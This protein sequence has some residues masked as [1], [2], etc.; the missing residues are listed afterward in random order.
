M[1]SEV[2]ILP[3]RLHNQRFVR[4]GGKHLAAVQDEYH[5]GRWNQAR[6][7]Y[8][9]YFLPDAGAVDFSRFI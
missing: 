9:A 7:I 2:G 4:I 5:H 8:K 3:G 1:I 6:D